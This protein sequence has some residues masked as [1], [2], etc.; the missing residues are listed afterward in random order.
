MMKLMTGLNSSYMYVMVSLFRQ[1]KLRQSFISDRDP[2]KIEKNMT[3]LPSPA[4]QC[5]Q[6]DEM[7]DTIQTNEYW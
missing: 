3:A 7:N 5:S 2:H 1:N 4:L 6:Y